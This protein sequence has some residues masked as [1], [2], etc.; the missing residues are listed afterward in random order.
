MKKI[1]AVLFL[2][3]LSSIFFNLKAQQN[4]YQESFLKFFGFFDYLKYVLFNFNQALSLEKTQKYFFDFLNSVEFKEKDLEKVKEIFSRFSIVEISFLNSKGEIYLQQSPFPGDVITHDLILVGK[5]FDFDLK[6]KKVISI[7]QPGIELGLANS[8]GKIL[9]IGKTLGFG[10]IELNL[11]PDETIDSDDL[12]FTSGQD[13][14]FRKG[15]LVGKILKI[16]R[17]PFET[18]VIIQSFFKPFKYHYLIL[19]PN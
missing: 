15:H 16:N 7:F 10:L 1:I 17:S 13:G 12:I 8:K 18:K 9:G 5:L 14:I 4:F 6:N 19:I 2:I 3:F 11:P